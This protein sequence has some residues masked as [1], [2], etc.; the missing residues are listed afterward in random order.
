MC[1]TPWIIHTEVG[2]VAGLD[3]RGWVEELNI[4]KCFDSHKGTYI[5][6]LFLLFLV[7]E[8]EVEKIKNKQDEG[9]QKR[10]K[11]LMM[12]K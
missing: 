9:D 12:A 10:K 3:Q 5:L 11:P 4:T 8:F 6:I 2:R 7:D 1:P